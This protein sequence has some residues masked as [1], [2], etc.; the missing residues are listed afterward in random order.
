MI[1]ISKDI[2]V[3]LSA[4]KIHNDISER[5][6]MKNDKIM[7]NWGVSRDANLYVKC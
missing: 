1:C 5:R 4:R 6:K 3:N 7:L 2:K